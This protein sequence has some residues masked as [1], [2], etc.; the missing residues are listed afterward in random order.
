MTLKVIYLLGWF[1]L[2]GECV[3]FSQK[4]KSP[5]DCK[6]QGDSL[7]LILDEYDIRK[8]QFACIDATEYEQS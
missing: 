6:L 8:Y 7:K 5:D 3:T 2:N 1:C 4:H